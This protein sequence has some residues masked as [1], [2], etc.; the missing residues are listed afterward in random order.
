MKTGLR[1]WLA[2]GL[3]FIAT[4]HGSALTTTIP[5]NDRT[6]FYA[7]VDKAGEKVS[8]ALMLRLFE[9]IISRLDSTLLFNPEA[10]SILTM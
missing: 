5:A 10:P 6:C 3:A 7:A 9:L 2:A 8:S 4:V 1:C